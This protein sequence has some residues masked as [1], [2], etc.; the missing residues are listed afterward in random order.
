ML[1]VRLLG[2]FDARRDG[3]PI[4]VPSRAAQ[5]LFAFLLLNAGVAH[6]REKLAGLLWPDTSEERARSNLKQE[7]WRLRKAIELKQPRPNVGRGR[8]EKTSQLK[9]KA[10]ELKQP[11]P[12]AVPYILSDDITI[13]FNTDAKYWLDASALERAS[14]KDK[15]GSDLINALSL[16]RDEL[17]PGF[18]DEWV[19][20][21]RERLRGVFEQKVVLLLERLL[22]GGWWAEV[23]E[24]AE[25]WIALER[26]PEAAF[27]ALM[28]FYSQTGEM[29]K[30]V[31][32]YE[33]LV[34]ALHELDIEPSEQTRTHFERLKSGEPMLKQESALPLKTLATFSTQRPVKFETRLEKSATL[35]PPT[36]TVTFLFTDIEGSTILWEKHPDTMEIAIARHNVL[37]RDAIEESRGYV[38]KTI[39]DAFCAAFSNALDALNASLAAQRALREEN[40]GD[41]PIKARMSLHTG[42]VEEHEG[43]YFGRAVNRV[44]RLL[45][46]GHGGQTLISL[47]TAE[48]V[49]DQLPGGVSLRDLGERRLKDLDRPEHIYQL[50]V[51]DLPSDFPPLKT[52]GP[53]PNNLPLSLTSFI[54]RERAIAEVMRLLSTTRLLTLTGAGGVGKTRLALE[55]GADLLDRFS[56]GVR[57]IALASLSDP[58]LVTQTVMAALGLREQAARSLEDTLIDYLREKSLLLILDNCEHMPQACARLAAAL[59]GTCARLKIIASSRHTLNISG[60]IRWQ[61][62]PLSLPKT[63]QT[64]EDSIDSEAVRLFIERAQFVL[65]SFSV[66]PANAETV[67]QI[68]QRLDGL[69]LAIELAA[70]SID[71]LSPEEIN[72]GIE[73]RFPRLIDLKPTELPQHQTLRACVDWS[74]NLLSAHEQI[75]FR[76]LSVFAGTW[77]LE[78]V[79]QICTDDELTRVQVLD[80]H[81]SLVR[82]SLVNVEVRE[83]VS[84]Y[85]LL[86][87]LRRYAFERLND[88]D[89]VKRLSAQHRDWYLHLAEAFESETRDKKQ[90]TDWLARLSHEL[91]NL[92]AA[93]EWSLNETGGADKGLRLSS[94]L[95]RFWEKQIAL[96]EGREWL[97]KFINLSKNSSDTLARARALY[98]AG[99]LAHLQG[100]YANAISFFE[101]CLKIE[102][103]DTMNLAQ[104]HL[105]L[106]EAFR[107]L[108]DYESAVKHFH[109]AIA[110][111]ETI[112]DSVLVA[113][114]QMRL[115]I[116]YHETGDLERAVA[117]HSHSLEAFR[118]A[119]QQNY[120]AAALANLA[121]VYYQRTDYEKAIEE[122]LQAIKLYENQNNPLDLSIV[123]N[124]LGG[125]FM[126]L[127][128]F[129]EAVAYL[130]KC[131]HI[132]ETMENDFRQAVALG[133][134]AECQLRLGDLERAMD[135][136]TRA[137]QHV[138]KVQAPHH[139]GNLYRIRGEIQAAQGQKEEAQKDFETARERLE[140][141]NQRSRVARLYR[142]YGKLLQAESST[143]AQGIEYLERAL[144][145][146]EALGS[147]KEVEKTKTLIHGAANKTS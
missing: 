46:A 72:K 94:A 130:N 103:Q 111:G 73:N 5:S 110:L 62:P 132:A 60:E 2:Q 106:G 39:G 118:R 22:A 126:D 4:V 18:Y 25:R 125:V 31:E 92:R 88:S 108:L 37:V 7:L 85:R 36:G 11:R 121:R 1:E 29:A 64:L 139:E 23:R 57:L 145:L 83:G 98:A 77:T 15:S 101:Q 93:L 63:L 6:R 122:Y 78:D 69:P 124:N 128:N 53:F 14:G 68:C 26:T 52:L 120:V 8:N 45:S 9:R 70:G 114:A 20:S 112:Q 65:P 49:R 67:A 12:D 129:T 19:E 59:L 54:G 143:R 44:A 33:R 117:S 140:P 76:R 21:E 80:L 144:A 84:R 61:V 131:M 47:A 105:D 43:D 28:L 71:V 89:E 96:T 109:Q 16:Y 10:I 82:K 81:A 13:T 135:F 107:H 138:R 116:V 75:L 133:D 104:T 119:G 102:P 123:Y 51:P 137:L 97:G 38:F 100:D 17:L 3:I 32:V 147:V 74:W 99:L 95:G 136:I 56:D 142:S 66:T 48:L 90:T 134:L 146:F 50:V 42:S 35:E 127:G 58:A 41:T 30:V 79:E 27:R 24:W 40:W 34:E 113:L 91:D 87:I 141:L 55:V 86:E 115:G